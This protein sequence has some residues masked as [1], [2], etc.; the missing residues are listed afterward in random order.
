[1]NADPFKKDG[2]MWSWT[3]YGVPIDQLG[4]LMPLLNRLQN[5]DGYAIET[6]YFG[7]MAPTA[8]VLQPNAPLAI[9][10]HIILARRLVTLEEFNRASNPDAQASM[11]ES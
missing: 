1:M 2:F 6:V 10:C 8:S 4:G 9:P 11:K 3:M 7:M 5:E